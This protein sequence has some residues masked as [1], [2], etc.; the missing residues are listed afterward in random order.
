MLFDI[1][2][3]SLA[4]T[5]EVSLSLP[6]PLSHPLIPFPRTYFFGLLRMVLKA[7]SVMLSLNE[8]DLL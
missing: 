1:H 4:Y 5:T 2:L 3:S 7:S 8:P 6:L